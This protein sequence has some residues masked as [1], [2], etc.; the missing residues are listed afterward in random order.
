M[1][2]QIKELVDDSI[3]EFNVFIDDS[4]IEHQEGKKILNIVVDSEDIIDLNRITD[5]SRVINDIID[6]R[7]ENGFPTVTIN[8]TT[9]TCT[10]PVYV[11]V[12]NKDSIILSIAI[13]DKDGNQVNEISKLGGDYKIKCA[14][15]YGD[16]DGILDNLTNE[17]CS[18]LIEPYIDTVNIPINNSSMKEYTVICNYL[19][20]CVSEK[21]QQ[22]GNLTTVVALTPSDYS[23]FEVS[24]YKQII[25]DT[26]PETGDDIYQDFVLFT[27]KNKGK[28]SSYSTMTIRINGYENF[29]FY[30]RSY[31]ESSYDYVMVSQLDTQISSNTSYSNTTLV[32]AHTRGNQ[33][34]GTAL[35]NYKLVEFT[36]IDG[37]EH[38]ITVVY[39]KDGSSASGDDKG[40]ILIPKNQ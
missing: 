2:D 16:I 20:K 26:D 6:A 9:I 30:I 24:E 15:Y 36:G 27:N 3:K 22:V 4:F 12:N 32:K 28:H 39:R 11:D 5:V 7:K 29:S 31:A 38:R 8:D 17:E 19:G 40:Y 13:F 23:G 1:K 21:I 25:I 18:E 37:G 33:Q 34:Y 10:S 35:S 14:A